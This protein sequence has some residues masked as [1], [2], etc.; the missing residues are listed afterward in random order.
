M[1]LDYP[2]VM[3]VVFLLAFSTFSI[4]VLLDNVENEA[5]ELNKSDKI[6]LFQT[7]NDTELVGRVNISNA[8]K[9]YID[10]CKLYNGSYFQTS[11]GAFCKL[12]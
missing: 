7:Y 8:N 10:I 1:S 12:S 2:K 4:V 6:S 11:R 9:S 3:A 5:F